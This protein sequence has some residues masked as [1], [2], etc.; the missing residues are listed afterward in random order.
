MWATWGRKK[1]PRS[2][3]KNEIKT[4][5]VIKTQNWETGKKGA[6]EQIPSKQSNW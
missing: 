3:L 6:K 2:D 1:S 5:S 4:K